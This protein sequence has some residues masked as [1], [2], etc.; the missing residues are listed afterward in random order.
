MNIVTATACRLVK[1]TT[2]KRYVLDGL[3]FGPLRPRRALIFVHGLG[4]SAFSHPDYLIPFVNRETA[5][6]YF[7][8]RGHDT[9][10]RLRRRKAGAKNK[11]VS[12]SGGMAHEVFTGC[13]DDL[14]GA[15][16]LALA[17]HAREIVLVGHSTGCQKIIYSLSR[18]GMPRQVRGAILLC[19]ISD[20]AAM[21]HARPRQRSRAEQIARQFI[22]RGQAHRLL[23]PE[24]W[25]EPLDAQRFLSLYTPDS[26]EEVF[27][28]A[29]PGKP[30]RRLGKVTQPLLIVL[31]GA[32]EY[33]DRPSEAMAAW[34]AAHAR[35]GEVRI[36]T[37]A[38]H[39]FRGYEKPLRMT[40]RRW[41]ARR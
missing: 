14:Q 2:P 4:S 12:E 15:A 9:I 23:P 13:A 19:P 8:N 22:R 21:L 25:P 33:R 1:I 34:F 39:G 20:Y 36:I 27:P 37:G 32:D 31:A 16:A 18:P 5:V 7:N 40:L 10:A 35:D 41:L 26:E 11:Y 24:I 17:H 3:W 30:A 6:L 28:Y 38:K 29:Q